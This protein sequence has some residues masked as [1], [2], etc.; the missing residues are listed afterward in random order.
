V[1]G[2]TYDLKMTDLDK[3][4]ILLNNAMPTP[5]ACTWTGTRELFAGCGL[6]VLVG[7]CSC[8]PLRCSSELY[9]HG[10]CSYLVGNLVVFE[11]PFVEENA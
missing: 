3:K 2:L 11:L 10:N 1:S 6:G 4:N 9:G 8:Q 7:F 5:I